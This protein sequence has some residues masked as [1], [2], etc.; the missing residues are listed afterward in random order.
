[1][2]EAEVAAVGLLG[3]VANATEVKVSR[4][5]GTD[6]AVIDDPKQVKRLLDSI[7]MSQK[8]GDDCPPRL[9]TFTLSFKDGFGKRLGSLGVYA[10]A[11]G[12]LAP[13]AVLRDA[14][15]DECQSLVLVETTALST[16]LDGAL[17]LSKSDD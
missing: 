7:G 15:G 6:S 12:G 8:P 11:S 14:L 1:M 2:P 17:P 16:L 10:K 9:P 5:D 4:V 13:E 3:P